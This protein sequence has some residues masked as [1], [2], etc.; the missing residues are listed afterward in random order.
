MQ[1]PRRGPF[2]LA[3]LVCL[4]ECKGAPPEPEA[5]ATSAPPAP[6]MAAAL[7]AAAPASS[8]VAASAVAPVLGGGK[9]SSK[10]KHVFVIPLEN[11]DAAQVYSP[12]NAPYIHGL[13]DKY[14]H[15]ENFDDQLPHEIPSEPHYVWMEAGTNRFSDNTFS[16]D[17]APSASNSTGSTQH[18]V[19]QLKQAGL[20]WTAYQE[21]LNERTG[22]CPIRYFEFYAPKHNPFVFFRDVSGDP[23][24][25]DN[26]Y[27]V[28]HHKPYSALAADLAADKLSPYV[29]ITPNQCHDM[30]GQRGCPGQDL[31]RA[32]DDWL[33]TALPPLIAYADQQSSVIFLVWDEGDSSDKL[34]FLALGPMIKPHY[35]AQAH[36]THS[37]LLKSVELMLGVPVLA[38]VAASPDLGELFKPGSFP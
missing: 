25:P 30:H 26:A 16:D 15:A 12:E 19:T 31:V 2:W 1:S 23:P 38:T 27:C 22:A 29:F 18:L 24:S 9:R 20:D 11:H 37:A 35:A 10:I 34:P 5:H 28:A 6:A 4:N 13:L 17:S 3:L 36:Y 33:R 32:G 7:R 8:A 21:G 14:A